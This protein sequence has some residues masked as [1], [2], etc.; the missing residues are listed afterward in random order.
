ML[1]EHEGNTEG[2]IL[3]TV[4]NFFSMYFIKRQGHFHILDDV[5][6]NSPR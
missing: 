1:L 3:F 4:F 5:S 6:L 2:S